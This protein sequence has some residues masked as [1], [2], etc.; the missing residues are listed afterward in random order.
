MRRAGSSRNTNPNMQGRHFWWIADV[1]RDLP[2]RSKMSRWDVAVAFA[3][4]CRM[5]NSSFKYTYFLEA[6]E[7][8]EPKPIVRRPRRPIPADP[9]KA[10][11]RGLDFTRG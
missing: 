11:I 2:E 3:D 5:T 8:T 6:C 7:A 1:I 10:R 9:I 4:A